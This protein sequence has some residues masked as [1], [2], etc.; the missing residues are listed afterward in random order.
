M[1]ENPQHETH[2]AVQ[3]L[4]EV[5]SNQSDVGNPIAPQATPIRIEMNPDGT[6]RA[7]TSLGEATA[8]IN[9]EGQLILTGGDGLTGADGTGGE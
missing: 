2:Q 4:A 6:P 1:H 5:A 9:H 8:T 7:I 3:T